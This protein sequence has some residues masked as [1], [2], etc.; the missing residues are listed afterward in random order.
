MM[1]DEP[2]KADV[3]KAR[4]A[5]CREPRFLKLSGDTQHEL[6]RLMILLRDE[7]TDWDYYADFVNVS[8]RWEKRERM[9]RGLVEFIDAAKD[10]VD[11]L[12][13]MEM[14]E[15]QTPAYRAAVRAWLSANPE[16]EP[17]KRPRM[18]DKSA[19]AGG[20]QEEGGAHVGSCRVHHE[21]H[22]TCDGE[23]RRYW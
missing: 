5:V 1:R 15:E 10:N 14:E 18:L 12:D 11:L 22:H 17:T 9:R 2:T 13:Q 16:V 3:A 7:P 8:K 4:D 21:G 23:G 19:R 6:C 20:V